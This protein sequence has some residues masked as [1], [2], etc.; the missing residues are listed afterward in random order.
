MPSLAE[1]LMDAVPVGF[2]AVRDDRLLLLNRHMQELTGFSDSA[3][4]VERFWERVPDAAAVR[5]HLLQGTPVRFKIASGQMERWLEFRGADA[6]LEEHDVLCGCLVEVTSRMRFEQKM[7]LVE[8][9]S[10]EMKV[11]P[12]KAAVYGLV[13]DF[14]KDLLGY[15][16]CAILERDGDALRIALER[17][18]TAAEKELRLPLDGDGIT[19]AAF[20][21]DAAQYVPDVRGDDRYI[22]GVPGARCEYAIPLTFKDQTFGVFDVQNDAVDSIAP[23][24]RALLS[25]LASEMATV[26]KSLQTL[27]ELRESENRYRILVET[28][29]EGIIKLDPDEN[30]LFVNRSMS[31]LIGYS[32]E[33]LVGKSLRDITTAEQYQVFQDKTRERQRH[34]MRDAYEAVLRHRNGQLLNVIVSAT[35]YRG[36]DGLFGGTFAIM[37]DITRMKEAEEQAMF[38]HSL[39]RHD[40]RNKNQVIMGYLE[41]LMEMDLTEEQLELAD[42]AFTSLEANNRLIQKVRELQRATEEQEL[43]PVALDSLLADIVGE[44]SSQL[45]RQDIEVQYEPVDAVV[46]GNELTREMF[47]N[48]IGNAVAHSDADVI[49]I[50]G[51]TSPG[52]VSVSIADDGRGIPEAIKKDIFSRKVKGSRSTG[53]G[54]GL[55]LVKTI[56]ESQGGSV[57]VRDGE[58]GGTV[59]EV[60]LRRVRP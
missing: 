12:D 30:I 40:I 19:V 7:R 48:V 3:V 45:A 50:T 59:F 35:P 23:E 33:E 13:M 46:Q 52:H 31:D 6:R 32:A 44:F 41:L 9:A 10:R 16:N 8:A 11:A 15:R 18:Y 5:E 14:A 43:Q 20:V 29:K 17:G 42:H 57:S 27:E 49:T 53:S 24:D 36:A 39:L 34:G 56:V 22:E 1:T 37:T 54:L 21:S 60:L 2:F 25:T 51:R 26:L 55:Y 4:P 58:N 28:A 47:V 38:Y